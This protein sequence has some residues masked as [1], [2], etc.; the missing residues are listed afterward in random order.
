METG[1]CG[2]QLTV[3]AFISSLIESDRVKE[4][5]LGNNE[6]NFAST[7][8]VITERERTRKREKKRKRKTEM[9]KRSPLLMATTRQLDYNLYA[10]FSLSVLH[11][12]P[13]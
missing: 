1:V 10:F 13:N 4:S 3:K 9:E 11:I 7:N 8:S 6:D 2:M 5:P 12:T